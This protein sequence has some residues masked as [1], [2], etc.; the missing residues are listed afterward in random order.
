[1]PRVKLKKQN[2]T[3]GLMNS[4][5][6]GVAQSFGCSPYV[7]VSQKKLTEKLND[8][9]GGYADIDELIARVI[10]LENSL[11]NTKLLLMEVSRKANQA[12]KKSESA[13][14]LAT[15]RIIE[16]TGDVMGL[17]QFDGSKDV[18]I[19]TDVRPAS[20]TQEGIVKLSDSL[21]NNSTSEAA[22]ANSVNILYNLVSEID[23]KLT[24]IP[25]PPKPINEK[26]SLC[27]KWDE[28]QQ[29][30]IWVDISKALG[31]GG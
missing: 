22:T 18:E 11:K 4:L 20:L 29:K 23:D 24:S 21:E 5:N 12:L 3:P 27:L 19:L 25:K 28:D 26:S 7:P 15:P 8:G 1:M 6:L 2:I 17:T 14:K 10:E 30:Y 9:S 16:L 31:Y 13:D